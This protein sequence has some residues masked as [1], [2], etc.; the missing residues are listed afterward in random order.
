MSKQSMPKVQK[1]MN[2]AFL[3]PQK[4]FD[5]NNL[6]VWLAYPGIYN[7]GM[8]AL[9][10]LTVFQQY[11][12]DENI[13]AERIFIDT[14]TTQI[15]ARKLNVL[16]FSFSFELDFLSIFKILEKF[17]IPLYAKDRD[18][19]FPLIAGGGPVLTANPEPFCQM[20]D[21]IEI[22]DA[23]NKSKIITDTIRLNLGKSKKDILIEL[24][25]I[26][27]VYVPAFTVF[28]EK[29]GMK[30]LDGQ[31]YTVKKSTDN[32]QGNCVTTPILTEKSF[33]KNTYII[34]IARGC[35]QKCAF[36]NTS[37]I[38]S[39]YR[40]CDYDLITKKIDDALQYTHK[41][42]FLGAAIA[43]H[44]RFEDLCEYVANKKDLYPDIE[45]SVSSLRAD[46]VSD[47]V[48]KSLVKCG[49]KHATIAL[50]A[51]SE[52][53]RNVI[54]KNLTNIQFKNTVKTLRENGFKGVKIYAMIGLPTETMDDIQAFVDFT[55]ELKNENKGFD[56]SLGFS[57]FVPKAH[58]PFQFVEKENS[59]SLE[60][61]YEFLKKEMHKIGIKINVSGVKW[62]F[63]QALFSRGGRDLFDYAVEVYNQGGNIGAFKSGMKMFQ[64][65]KFELIAEGKREFNTINPWD[66]IQMPISKELLV[67][68]C[69]AI[70]IK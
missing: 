5:K 51:G 70:L 54:N 2:E 58:T 68:K 13:N 46:G 1:M 4:P 62:D 66:F 63:V 21:Y 55:K 64:N 53:L 25:K 3:Y 56:I 16:S 35:P 22:G 38:N 61:K 15:D 34:E 14:K 32:L 7:F 40:V 57:S 60:A 42:A 11:D 23:E 45:L 43:A 67:K 49:Q 10:F 33:F 19:S 44:P 52:R 24:A 30:T 31:P 69:K 37:H 29:N 39:P 27:G 59:K 17:H 48:A 8:S 6:N 20:F 12:S 26:E 9:G 36:C 28:D 41:F 18:D 50:E 47:K 65:Q